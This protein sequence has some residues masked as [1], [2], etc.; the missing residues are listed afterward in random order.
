[1]SYWRLKRWLPRL[2]GAYVVAGLL[3]AAA[4]G[5][6]VFPFFCWFLFPIVPGAEPRYELV[7]S[8]HAGTAVTPPADVQTLDVVRDPMA[9]DLWLATQRLGVAL[10]KDDSA[11]VSRERRLIEANF[12]CAPSRYR[13]DRV[14]FDPLARYRSGEVTHR[15][16]VQAFASTEGCRRSPW[17]L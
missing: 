11:A 2:G 14:L 15:E 17:A 12:V 9:M 13:I 1:M 3:A 5:F 16:T 4:P 6:E 8:E 10:A 7:V